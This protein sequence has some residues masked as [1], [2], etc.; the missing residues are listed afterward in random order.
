[1]QITTELVDVSNNKFNFSVDNT[2]R[3]ILSI[4]LN[5]NHNEMLNIQVYDNSN[6]Y[7]CSYNKPVY[8]T[9]IMDKSGDA[10]FARQKIDINQLLYLEKSKEYTL[11]YTINNPIH[12]YAIDLEIY[13]EKKYEIYK[14]ITYV[15]E[16]I[17]TPYIDITEYNKYC[18]IPNISSY[19]G[20]L[21]WC[22]RL[23][24]TGIALCDKHN[25][26]PIID[27]NGGLYA[28]NSYYDPKELPVSWWNYYFEDPAPI[29]K[30]QKEH[31]IEHSRK[32]RQIMSFTRPMRRN[33]EAKLRPINS[34]NVYFYVRSTY[35]QF[36]R[37]FMMNNNAKET[38]RKFLK[39]LPYIR[40]YCD[41]FWKNAKNMTRIGVHYRGTDKYATG[42]TSEGHPIHYEYSTVIKMIETK[43]K[44][45]DINEYIVYGTSDEIPFIKYMQTE[46]KDKFITND[47]EIRSDTCTSGQ[48]LDMRLIRFSKTNDKELQKVYDDNKGTAIH[49]GQ[50]ETSNYLKGLYSVIDCL[51]LSQCHHIF[52]SRG[53]FSDFAGYM[54]DDTSKIYDMNEL[55]NKI[56][57]P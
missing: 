40:E 55:Y 11:T 46:L 10:F 16:H 50:K 18:I 13:N 49:F 28:T 8:C 48:K 52:C 20:G 34:Q 29:N 39:P 45:L 5:S 57:K 6:N 4:T 26:I 42:T 22:V 47:H 7:V 43:M 24:L 37:K 31:L 9:G 32:Q 41:D 44:E 30:L 14:P 54:C 36:F 27:H 12:V 53:N 38:C 21:W 33:I 56:D 35:N 25:I 15:P 2:D 51:L 3:Y 19:F 23:A 17:T 1:M